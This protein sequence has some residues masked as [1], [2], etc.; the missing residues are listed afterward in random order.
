MGFSFFKYNAAKYKPDNKF[1]TNATVAA[2]ATE[3]VWTKGG[4]YPF[5]TSAQN[6]TVV[7]DS[8]ED[9]VG[10]TGVYKVQLEGLDINYSE[11]K[12]VVALNGTT[13]V[14]TDSE[15]FRIFRVKCLDCGS[16]GSNVGTIDVSYN[17]ITRAEVIPLVGQT[18]MMI[19]T[20]P[21]GRILY[22][23]DFVASEQSDKPCNISIMVRERPGL[24]WR[25]VRDVGLKGNISNHNETG[26]PIVIDSRTDIRVAVTAKSTGAFVSAEIC[27]TSEIKGVP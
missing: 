15:F 27:A 9:N 2:N 26:H 3:D 1:G 7:S 5:L 24:S 12:E 6:L 20:V 17:S 25:A 4:L 22:I 14:V 11:I 8:T 23:W 21:E 13:P 19:W 18:K 10:E 16:A